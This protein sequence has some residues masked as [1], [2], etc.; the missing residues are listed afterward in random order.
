[1]RNNFIFYNEI[2]L[3]KN[4]YYFRERFIQLIIFNTDSRAKIGIWFLATQNRNTIFK[5]KRKTNQKLPFGSKSE[6]QVRNYLRI[7]NL[8]IL[9][10][11]CW[12]FH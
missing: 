1:M 7:I 5:I 4:M 11:N 3:T 6:M 2:V 8:E 10:R 9:M 12:M